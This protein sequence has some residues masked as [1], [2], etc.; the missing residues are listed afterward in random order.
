M[1]VK[2]YLFH[3]GGLVAEGIYSVVA[4]KAHGLMD[5]YYMYCVYE[6][7]PFKPDWEDSRNADVPEE[8]IPPIYRTIILM[9]GV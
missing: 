2:A 4:K 8:N 6:D 7:H 5:N 9:L 1:T 3:D